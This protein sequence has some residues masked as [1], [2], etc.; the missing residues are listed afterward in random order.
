[1]IRKAIIILI[2][3]I[4]LSGCTTW[5]N[6]DITIVHSGPDGFW[7]SKGNYQG[8]VIEVWKINTPKDSDVTIDGDKVTYSGKA[9][10]PIL[11]LLYYKA[12]DTDV[13]ISNKEGK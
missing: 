2:A 6:K 1:M 12:A 5:G 10:N 4:F 7:D 11:D 9:R 8:D 13:I 3:L